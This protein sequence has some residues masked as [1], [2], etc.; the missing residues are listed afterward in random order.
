MSHKQS[1]AGNRL[2]EEGKTGTDSQSERRME[3][4]DKNLMKHTA[5]AIN[6]IETAVI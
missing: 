6:G 3:M 4:W 2:G 1:G 5:S